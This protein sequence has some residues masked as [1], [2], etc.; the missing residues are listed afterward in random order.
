MASKPTIIGLREL[1]ENTET[2]IKRVNRGE[3]ITVV[4]RSTPVFKLTP[5]DAEETGWESVADFTTL[6]ERGVGIDDV[7]AA[8]RKLDADLVAAFDEKIMGNLEE[9][10]GAVA[11][12]GVAAASAAMLEALEYFNTRRDQAVAA[13]ATDVAH[14]ADAA[15]V[16]FDQG[17]GQSLSTGT[18]VL[19]HRLSLAEAPLRWRRSR[20][21]RPATLARGYERPRTLGK[22][23]KDVNQPSILT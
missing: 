3:S 9:D 14:E 13:L 8:L 4:R 19:H 6:D 18:K 12:L 23:P 15:G 2:Y 17:R 16:A 11:G 5:V 20:R 10:A 21:G 7:I 1:R 22:H